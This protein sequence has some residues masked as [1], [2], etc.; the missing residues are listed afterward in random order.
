V[1]E[2][3]FVARGCGKPY[4]FKKPV[5]FDVFLVCVRLNLQGFKNLEGLLFDILIILND[6]MLIFKM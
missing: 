4:R 2:G 3:L 1:E 5:S 6:N